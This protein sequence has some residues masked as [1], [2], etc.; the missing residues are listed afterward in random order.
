VKIFSLAGL[1]VFSLASITFFRF[2]RPVQTSTSGQNYIVV[3][4]SIWRHA[5]PDLGD[6]RLYAGQ[7]ETPYSLITEQGTRQLSRTP[8]PVLQ[9]S[10]V[11]KNTQF[12]L[13]MSGFAQYDHIELQLATKDFVAHAVVEGSDDPHSR[14]WA[15]LGDGILY[16]LSKDSLGSNTMLRLPRATYKYLRV[17][18]DGP[19][20]PADVT[21][22]AS[23]TGEDRPTLWRDVSSTFRQQQQAKDTV[24]T[25]DIDSKVPIDRV[26]FAIDASQPNFKRS[27]DIENEKGGWLGSG[28]IDRIHMVRGGRKIDAE[29]SEVT[30]PGSQAS[31]QKTL[32]VV[33]HN[34]DDPPLK[35]TG[36]RLQQLERRLYFDATPQALTLYYGD[37][38]LEA[39]VY[40][41]AKL[42]QREK[43]AAAATLGAEIPN[44]AYTGRPDE[45]PWSE[46]H[47]VVLWLAIIAAVVILG[48]VALRSMRKAS[49]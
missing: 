2:Q 21:G 26:L 29:D 1:L 5:R 32:K 39:P 15:R 10:T 38:K 30:I 27:V 33:I 14:N 31:G 25:F 41:Y 11:G 46:R 9:Q 17:T 43:S 7:Q 49:A 19:V 23:E 36:A 42:F 22:A 35:L 28:E 45:R 18:I 3:D 44:P 12:L 8:V 37:E 13:D 47:P 40:D 24:L 16:D 4:D 34:G 6:L 20:K 48:S